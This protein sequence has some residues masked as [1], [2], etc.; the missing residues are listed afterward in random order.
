MDVPLAIEILV[1]RM[2]LFTRLIIDLF[3]DEKYH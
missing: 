1:G 2:E 3:C